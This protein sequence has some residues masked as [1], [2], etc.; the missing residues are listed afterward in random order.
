M[1]SRKQVN[2]EIKPDELVSFVEL[3][4]LCDFLRSPI[5]TSVTFIMW[6]KCLLGISE[7][8]VVVWRSEKKETSTS[9]QRICQVAS[10]SLYQ[11]LWLCLILSDIFVLDATFFPFVH[12]MVQI[13]P[14]C[15][16][17]CNIEHTFASN[18]GFLV[19]M[20][21]LVGF[22]LKRHLLYETVSFSLP[23]VI[24]T[25]LI[26]CPRAASILTQPKTL[27]EHNEPHS[28]PLPNRQNR[29]SVT[30]ALQCCN[31]KNPPAWKKKTE[32]KYV[33]DVLN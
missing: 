10:A 21:I 5:N 16:F 26:I 8:S 18:G 29:H 4:R 24:S 17:L 11:W 25:M 32:T 9:L 15:I 1:Q 3:R 28:F 12:M 27:M 33:V 6:Q 23:S 2:K 22:V 13:W 19:G 20:Q 14:M 7:I 30:T 31:T